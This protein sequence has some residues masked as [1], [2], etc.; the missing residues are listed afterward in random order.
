[1]TLQ[2]GKQQKR[3]RERIL[4]TKDRAKFVNRI[5]LSCA[6]DDNTNWKR[7]S[8]CHRF[9]WDN[10]MRIAHLV[11]VNF[12]SDKC[13]SCAFNWFS[14]NGSTFMFIAFQVQSISQ[15][16]RSLFMYSHESIKNCTKKNID[17]K[18]K[19]ERVSERDTEAVSYSKQ[20]CVVYTQ[21]FY[22]KHIIEEE[23]TKKKLLLV[24][25]LTIFVFN[26]SVCPLWKIVR[27]IKHEHKSTHTL[28]EWIHRE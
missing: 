27:V 14:W 9:S 2:T 23:R 18:R 5:W 12:F 6:S 26:C 19:R 28:Y 8:K 20:L 16:E 11:G 1:M 22:Y 21:L 17:R 7:P 15:G 25:P 10:F 24:E 4:R 3:E 13:G